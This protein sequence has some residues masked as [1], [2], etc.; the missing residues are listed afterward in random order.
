MR[1]ALFYGGRDIRVEELP[2][3]TPGP[4]EV[5][6][7]IRAAGV[8]GSDLHPYRGAPRARARSEEHTSELQSPS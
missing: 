7:R 3:P 5:L 8:C 4:G 1:A 2:D 6:V